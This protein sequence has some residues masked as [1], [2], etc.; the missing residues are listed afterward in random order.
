MD[1]K[2]GFARFPKMSKKA[3]LGVIL[4]VVVVLMFMFGD[5]VAADAVVTQEGPFEVTTYSGDDLACEPASKFDTN[6]QVVSEYFKLA[7][8]YQGNDWFEHEEL[9]AVS[10]RLFMDASHIDAVSRGTVF[11]YVYETE[12]ICILSIGTKDPTPTGEKL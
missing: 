1:I 5:K 3:K 2:N 9:G 12:E 4:I 10:W 7:H 8:K 6:W 11:A